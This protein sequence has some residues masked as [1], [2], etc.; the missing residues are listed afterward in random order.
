[1]DLL[2]QEAVDLA[3]AV[4]A[5]LDDAEQVAQLTARCEPTPGR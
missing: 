1:M 3:V 5:D 4:R 2:V